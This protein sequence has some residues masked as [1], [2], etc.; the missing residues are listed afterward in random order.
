M[1]RGRN[2][3]AWRRYLR[4]WGSNIQ[5]ALYGVQRGDPWSFTLGG[6]ALLAISVAACLV[7]ILRATAVDPAVAVRAE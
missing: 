4:F 6:L 2:A 5:N 3:Q 1:T 7:P